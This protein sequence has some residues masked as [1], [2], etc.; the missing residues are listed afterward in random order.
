M[1]FSLSLPWYCVDVAWEPGFL[2][3]Q[4]FEQ[5]HMLRSTG[6]QTLF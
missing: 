4:D 1:V 5:Q 6:S 2:Q 3:M